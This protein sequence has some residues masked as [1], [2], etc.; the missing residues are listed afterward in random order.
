MDKTI[1]AKCAKATGCSSACAAWFAPLY[2]DCA[3]LIE[4]NAA[5]SRPSAYFKAD[6]Y[7]TLYGMC[8]KTKAGQKQQKVSKTSPKDNAQRVKSKSSQVPRM[9]EDCG[10]RTRNYGHP[11]DPNPAS[12][13]GRPIWRWC[14]QCAKSYPGHVQRVRRLG[15]LTQ[16]LLHRTAACGRAPP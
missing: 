1:D 6:A 4:K 3:Y 12:E 9:C 14:G 8:M 5:R 11:S 10:V 7:S 15:P 13:T 16:Q 2:T